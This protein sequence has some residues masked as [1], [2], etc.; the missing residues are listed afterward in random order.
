MHKINNEY[1]YIWMDF[2]E[3]VH[4]SKSA[5]VERL[6]FYIKKIIVWTIVCVL[7]KAKEVLYGQHLSGVWWLSQSK[8]VLLLLL[9]AEN[10][11][12]SGVQSKVDWWCMMVRRKQSLFRL[13]QYLTLRNI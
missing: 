1:T 13:I 4:N 2:W 12:R 6:G 8:R 7:G 9:Y 10:L 3:N 11:E 5:Y